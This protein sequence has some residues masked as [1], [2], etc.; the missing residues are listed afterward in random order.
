MS[1]S[2]GTLKA[3]VWPLSPLFAAAT[4]KQDL[5][6]ELMVRVREA[7]ELYLEVQGESAEPLDFIGV[8]KITVA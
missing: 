5:L 7:V 8:R 4:R 2:S 1:S 6:D 3:T